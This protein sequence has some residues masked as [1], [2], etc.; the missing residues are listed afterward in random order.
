MGYTTD[1]GGAFKLDRPLN[2]LQVTTLKEFAADR[3]DG[4]REVPGIWCQWVPSEDGESIEWDGNEKFYDYT[5]WLVY[6]IEKFLKP[7]GLIL[8]GS[9]TWH[10]EDPGDSGVIYA[11]D[12]R[13]KAVADETVR[14][15]PDWE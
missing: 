8:S 3:H 2:V 4:E 6:I 12:N 5:A 10:G 13:V 9:V 11:K 7:W 15:E 1:F 14:K